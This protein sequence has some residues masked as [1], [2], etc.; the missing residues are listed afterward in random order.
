MQIEC[1]ARAVAF[2]DVPQGGLCAF[3]EGAITYVGIKVVQQDYSGRPFSSCAVLWPAMAPTSPSALVPGDALET[4]SVLH[5][6]DAILQPDMAAR[7]IQSADGIALQPGMLVLCEAKLFVAVPGLR[8]VVSLIDV[9]D[10]EVALRLPSAAGVTF[11][12]WR[13][14]VPGSEGRE[15][16]C[17]WPPAH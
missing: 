7:S 5:W 11:D 16:I 15:T 6:P 3:A 17:R 8:G 9:Q 13:I 10:G 14:T 1:A 2:R 12:A 4:R